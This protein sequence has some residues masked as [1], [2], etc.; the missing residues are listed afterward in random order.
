MNYNL[1]ESQGIIIFEFGNSRLKIVADDEL[2]S[3][4][5]SF[6][7]N[8]DTN[9]ILNQVNS[10]LNKLEYKKIYYSTVNTVLSNFISS[11]IEMEDINYL[12]DDL[13]I[14]FSE[15]KGIGIDRKLGL[16]AANKL[17]GKNILTIDCG[18]AQTYNLAI[19]NKCEGGYITPGLKTRISSI[20]SKTNIKEIKSNEFNLAIGKNT[21]EA[22][23]NGVLIG[24]IEEIK[25]IIINLKSFYP[26]DIK[27]IITGGNS[28]I[29]FNALNKNDFSLILRNNLVT[30]GIK[31][32]LSNKYDKQ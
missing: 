20:F 30:D 19:K 8:N 32:L 27:C 5:Y 31:V 15:I 26:V 12:I 10:I 28:N 23:Y 17:C 2:F 1:Y 3:I 25:G 11:Q 29:I 21:K 14:D 4:D 7:N 16:I 24:I 6:L 18:T 13:I 9:I 22:I